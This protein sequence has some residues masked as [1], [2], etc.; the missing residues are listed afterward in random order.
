MLDYE[1]NLLRKDIADLKEHLE[2]E[3]KSDFTVSLEMMECDA[4]MAEESILRYQETGGSSE[5]AD[6]L[7]RLID[8]LRDLIQATRDYDDDRNALPPFL[9]GGYTEEK[10]LDDALFDI[11]MEY[12]D[13]DYEE[14]PPDVP[15]ECAD[16][17]D[18]YSNDA[19]MAVTDTDETFAV[20]ADGCAVED[21]GDNPVD[22][23]ERKRERRMKRRAAI[24]SGSFVICFSLTRHFF[25]SAWGYAILLV[26]FLIIYIV[27]PD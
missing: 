22:D 4:D 5:D 8:M 2:M 27:V 21:N 7:Q 19:D 15:E 12:G 23:E 20:T 3:R 17:E 14:N 1:K 26:I 11:S 16:D 25:P 6:E 9:C 13:M 24:F 18:A 10:R